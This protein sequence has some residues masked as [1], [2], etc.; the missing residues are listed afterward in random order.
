MNKLKVFLPLCIFLA[1]A[2]LIFGIYCYK[3]YTENHKY[4]DATYSGDFAYVS[5][6]KFYL[7][8]LSGDYFSVSFNDSTNFYSNEE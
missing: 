4:D 7:T 3:A 6:D 2:V 8:N 1:G 5:G